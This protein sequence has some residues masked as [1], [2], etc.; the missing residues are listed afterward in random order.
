MLGLMKAEPHYPHSMV[1]PEWCGMYK[2]EYGKKLETKDP[3]YKRVKKTFEHD[4]AAWRK[5]HPKS[6]E[7]FRDM[8]S[9]LS[10]NPYYGEA[11]KDT[12]L[13]IILAQRKTL[14]VMSTGKSV[15]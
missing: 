1:T 5:A 7:E 2:Q 11:K 14:C 3:V 8:V 4:K 9:T 12:L 13:R 6:E 15:A 10:L